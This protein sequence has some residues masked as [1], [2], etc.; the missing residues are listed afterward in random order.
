[1]A[2]EPETQ[3]AMELQKPLE[4]ASTQ[5][6][7][8]DALPSFASIVEAVRGG[9][10]SADS[11]EKLLAV[12]REL[13]ADKAK[14]E[15]NMAFAAFQA[16]CPHI[17]R[18]KKVDISTAGIAY[19]YADIETIMETIGPTLKSHGLSVSFDDSTVEGN[20]L[21]AT[22]RC[23]HIGGHSLVSSFKVT[24]DSKAG[25][26]PQQKYGSAATYAQRRALSSRLGLWTGDP[27]HDGGEPPEPSPLLTEQQREHIADLAGQVNQNWDDLLRWWN[28]PNFADA[29]QAKYEAAVRFLEQKK[30]QQMKGT[31]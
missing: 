6:A 19:T 28:V 11:V 15:Y 1:M 21:T 8:T 25:M 18:T 5:L 12:Y 31:Q 13:K 17:P 7:T 29:T 3:A 22:C 4:P 27:D 10:L 26:S 2:S 24:V 14:E 9:Q 30:Q 16:E 20:M 23:S